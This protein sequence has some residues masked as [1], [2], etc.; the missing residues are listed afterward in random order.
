MKD[1][2]IKIRQD[3]SSISMSSNRP[4]LD[5]LSSFGFQSVSVTVLTVRMCHLFNSPRMGKLQRRSRASK[6]RSL[7]C[8]EPSTQCDDGDGGQGWHDDG[9][10]EDVQIRRSVG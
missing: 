5:S 6:S 8:A 1:R 7:K 3:P 9:Y 10:H 4:Y 2:K